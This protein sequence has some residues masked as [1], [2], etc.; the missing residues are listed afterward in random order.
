MAYAAKGSLIDYTKVPEIPERDVELIKR[1]LARMGV[2][3]D[4][5]IPA[6]LGVA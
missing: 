5:E 1:L 3:N 4:A 2:S 6:M